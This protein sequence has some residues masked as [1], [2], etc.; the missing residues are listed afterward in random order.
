MS[1]V[2][3]FLWKTLAVLLTVGV[4]IYMGERGFS[5]NT[6]SIAV[7]DVA[8][9][10]LNV[11]QLYSGS[12]NYGTLTNTVALNADIVP[13]S[14]VS[15]ASVVNPWAGTV[16]LQPDAAPGWFDQVWSNVPRASCAKIVTGVSSAVQITVNGSAMTPP[17]DGGTAA[18]ACNAAANSITFAF[19]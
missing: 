5:G 19:N 2:L 16:T 9:L 13:Q 7:S 11:K 6:D 1:E 18:T 14:M 10:A 17:V 8:Q 4:V 12:A 15:G 3:G